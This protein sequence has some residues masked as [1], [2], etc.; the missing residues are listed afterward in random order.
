M[1]DHNKKQLK[2]MDEAKD[3]VLKQ[4]DERL[5]FIDKRINEN[6]KKDVQQEK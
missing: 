1:Q 6:D 5:V 4:L 3:H 2:R